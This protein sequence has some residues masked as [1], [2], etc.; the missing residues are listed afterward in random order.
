MSRS[1]I[2]DLRP[3]I[4]ATEGIA[5]SHDMEAYQSTVLRPIAKYQHDIIIKAF[6]A[7][8]SKYKLKLE[9]K[10]SVDKEEIINKAM[11]TN[12][13]LKCFYQGLVAG[14]LTTEEFDYYIEHRSELNKRITSLLMQRIVSVFV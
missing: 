1:D 11:K 9:G 8:P 6:E 14:M 3:T 10:S 2:K 13:E 4:P 7:Y 12:K 5:Y